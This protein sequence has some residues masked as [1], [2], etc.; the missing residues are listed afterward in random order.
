[1]TTYHRR[2][3]TR[4][5]V[6]V[7]VP[8][9]VLS[10]HTNMR[11]REPFPLPIDTLCLASSALNHLL[12]PLEFFQVLLQHTLCYVSSQV[13][14]VIGNSWD[15]KL[16]LCT[17]NV[18]GDANLHRSHF[19]RIEIPY[20]AFRSGTKLVALH[21]ACWFDRRMPTCFWMLDAVGQA[22]R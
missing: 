21:K 4:Q 15:A 22:R 1:M 11:L 7:S 6:P 14:V 18:G 10:V 19:G 9:T 17:T 2:S 16:S 5:T 12:L 13:S 8:T 3:L 20:Q